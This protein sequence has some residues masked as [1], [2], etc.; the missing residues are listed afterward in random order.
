MRNVCGVF[1]GAMVF[2]VASVVLSVASYAIA[3]EEGQPVPI[4]EQWS[5]W[6][7]AQ[8][9]ARREVVRDAE[10][11][12]LLWRAMRG[13]SMPLPDVPE[14]DF[15]RHMV[16]GVFMGT[17]PSG[18]Y[19]VRITRIVQNDKIVVSVKQTAPGPDDMVTMALT[20]PY[21]VVV[22][23]LSKKPIEFVAER[24]KP[25][26]GRAPRRDLIKESP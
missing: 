21:H 3:N 22:V 18:G 5:G 4:V 25:S 16:I 8:N 19:A 23:P 15:Q 2:A 20:S 13:R 1:A 10:G 7:S 9:A 6:N 26:S 14:I 12:K 11:W 24:E 17:K